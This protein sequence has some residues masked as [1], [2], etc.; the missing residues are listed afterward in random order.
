MKRCTMTR[1][2]WLS[3]MGTAAAGTILRPRAARADSLPTAPVAV[4]RCAS[5]GSEVTAALAVMFDQLGGLGR[6]VK[7]KTVAIK[8]NMVGDPW[9][10]LPGLPP[11]LTHWTNPVVI[12]ATVYHLGRAGARRIRIL[13]CGGAPEDPLEQW[14]ELAGWNPADIRNAA[15]NVE[16]ENTN[17]TGSADSYSQIVCPAG[18]IFPGYEVNHSYTDC[19]VFVSIPKMKEHHWF[20]ATLSMKNCYGMTPLTIYGDAAGVDEPGTEALGTRVGILHNGDRAPSLTA[21]QEI[22]PNSPR[23]GDY[24]LPRIIADIVSARP[25]DLAVIDGIQT[26]AGGEG[27]WYD[28]I[29]PISPGVLL[30]GLNPV[31]TDAVTLAVMG[32][33]PSAER[34]TPPFEGSDSF[35]TFAQE[36]GLGTRDLSRIEVLGTPVADVEFD[37]RRAGVAAP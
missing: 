22:D 37:V 8:I 36:L 3:G 18:H 15:G 21:P 35:L 12:G 14:M 33:D 20:G 32:F 4:T 30:A 19:D 23:A 17:G 7:G 28:N 5:Y 27:P 16:F 34:G 25:V 10:Q 6:L 26:I 1:R 2:A 24:R 29:R 9:M 31:T 13:E 11:E